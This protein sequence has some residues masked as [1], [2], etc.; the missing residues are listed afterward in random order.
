MSKVIKKEI[1][2]AGRKLSLE[3]GKLAA[4][5][6]AAIMGRYGDTVV[7]ATVCSGPAPENID[8]FP[9]SVEYLE[10]LYAGGRISSSRFIKREGRPSEKAVLSG[11]LVDRA[12]RPLFPKDY[13]KQV[14]VIITVL[15]VDQENDPAILG[16]ISASAA[17]SLSDVPWAG[18]VAA[19]RIGLEND[20]LVVNPTT[21]LSK[22]DMVVSGSKEAIVMVEAGA[23]I[24]PEEQVIKAL[25]FSHEQM[26]PVIALIEDLTKEAG[27][28]KEK[29]EVVKMDDE[30]EKEVLAYVQKEFIAN[31]TK[32]EIAS[33]EG[34]AD[35][36]KGEMEKTFAEKATPKD[37]AH[38]FEDEVHKFVRKQ[39]FENGKR[40]DGRD[41]SEIRSL[42]GEVGLL[43]RT[44]G[45]ALFQRGET[46]V[47][48]IVT[49]GSPSLEQLIEGA[50][51]EETKRYMHH[52]N[53]PPFC[54]GE[55]RR[56]GSPGRR[57][58]GHGSLAERALIPV[59]PPQD[60]FPYVIRVVSEVV[61]SAGSTSMGSV[62]ASTLSLMDA[63]VPLISP[64]AGIAMGLMTDNGKAVVLTDI[65]YTEDAHGDMDFKVAGTEDGITALQMDIKVTGVT[66]QILSEALNKAKE[67]RLFILKNML[68]VLPTFHDKLSPFAPRVSLIHIEPSKIGEVIGPGG[69]VINNII[70]QTGVAI[71][72]EDDGVV[73]ITGKEDEAIQKAIL[74]IQ[75]LTREIKPGEVYEGEVKRILPFG[76]FVEILPGKEGMVHISK[77]APQ[78]VERI[79]DVVKIG[80][81]LKVRVTEIDDQG[82][83]NLTA[84][85]DV[86]EQEDQQ[87]DRPSRPPFRGPRRH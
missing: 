57:V 35:R 16:L 80:Q 31:L 28:E 68:E 37:L 44:H 10:K 77:L 40:I 84:R 55:A 36:C 23:N 54:T 18:P 83:V 81:S 78:R 65:G 39:V 58:I 32:P 87:Q 3:T 27:C 7:L 53:F 52:Y 79:E 82:R 8:Y 43:P 29:Y 24:V 22:L 74:W 86:P 15:S 5:A 21:N 66:P 75:G 61:S 47:L 4:Q 51:G 85:L 62:C 34:W 30:V 63:G 11:R 46:H 38:L 42:N 2:F 50:T 64:V 1:E 6:N 49:L 12:I 13:F 67:A 26:Q 33:D 60:K 59:I 41:F 14:Q 19:V 48:S 17:L 76:A 9:L 71:D 70:A 56:L 20:T 45:S 72:I 69:R 73:T 25:S